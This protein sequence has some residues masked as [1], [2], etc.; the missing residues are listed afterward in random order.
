MV[1]VALSSRQPIPEL[2]ARISVS[3]ASKTLSF[4]PTLTFI[5]L[6]IGSFFSMS[7]T[8]KTADPHGAKRGRPESGLEPAPAVLG[9]F[10]P[11]IT[12]RPTS[13]KPP[14]LPTGGETIQYQV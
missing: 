8:A 12:Q 9:A 10:A 14:P 7:K 1:A 4:A 2:P 11:L 3:Y 6:E 5:S 13:G